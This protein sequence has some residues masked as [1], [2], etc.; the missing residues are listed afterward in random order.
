M[1]F[2]LWSCKCQDA[3]KGDKGSVRCLLNVEWAR[4][5]DWLTNWLSDMRMG[6]WIG[7]GEWETRPGLVVVAVAIAAGQFPLRTE[8]SI[9]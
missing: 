7:A 1:V 9:I 6:M 2:A 4:L 5:N 8:R 3:A